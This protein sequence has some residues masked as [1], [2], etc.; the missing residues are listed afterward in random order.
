LRIDSWS[1]ELVVRETPAGKNVNTE[2]EDMVRIRHQATTGE[3]YVC[4]GYSDLSS[5]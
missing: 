4:C 2:A 1:N 3:D 5:V